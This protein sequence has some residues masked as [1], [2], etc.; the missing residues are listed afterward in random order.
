MLGAQALGYGAMWRTGAPAYDAHVKAGLRLQTS[1]A[2]IGIIY[3][4]TPAM[5][6]RALSRP[7][8]SDFVTL[9]Q[10]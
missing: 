9:W 3:I 2:I 6:P 1:D 5:T 7:E 4:G 10:G 8:L